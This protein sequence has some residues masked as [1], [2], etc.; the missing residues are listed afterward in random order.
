[1]DKKELAHHLRHHPISRDL[2]DEQ[3]AALAKIVSVETLADSACIMHEGEIDTRLYIILSGRLAVSKSMPG[4]EQIPLHVLETG[5]LA[6]ELG[7]ISGERHT[8]SLCSMGASTVAV[9]ERSR[10]EAILERQPWL[11]FRLMC[12]LARSV[13]EIVR[14]M[15]LQHAE[16]SNYIHHQHGRY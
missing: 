8:A 14:R 7:F 13:H 10:L 9:L 6:G 3:C 2:S 4:G 1:M 11:V 5:D 16:L 15:N 12:A